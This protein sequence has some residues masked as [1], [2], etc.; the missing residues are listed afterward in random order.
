VRV[1]PY[2]TTVTM[3]FV[4]LALSLFSVTFAQTHCSNVLSPD[5]NY[6]TTEKELNAIPLDIMLNA[7]K[8]FGGLGACSAN[9]RRYTTAQPYSQAPFKAVGKV[10]FSIGSSDY[11]CSGSIG[12]QNR[13]LVWTA[14]HCVYGLSTEGGFYANWKFVPGYYNNVKPQGEFFASRLCA[15]DGYY[16]REDMG[17]DYAIA[18]MEDS[19][20][21]GIGQFALAVDYFQ[22]ST[23]M[24][25]N[26]YPAGAPFNGQWENTC[27]S[28]ACYVDDNFFPATTGISCDSTGGSSG[29][30]WLIGGTQIGSVNSY[31]YPTIPNIMFGPYFNAAT[32]TF[33]NGVG[34]IADA[35]KKAALSGK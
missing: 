31:G 20:P 25:S 24:V 29:G 14:G 11:V 21:V 33:Y 28:S 23:I 8:P 15:T 10:F 35:D 27:T 3:L 9:Y 13:G 34:A 19:L 16:R 7:T 18:I 2:C 5:R 12:D 32:R 30:P 4:L 17:Y 22:D 1:A 6:W 26:G